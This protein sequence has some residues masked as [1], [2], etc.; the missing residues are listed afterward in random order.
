MEPTDETLVQR[1]LNGD[2]EAFDALVRRYQ[3]PI[4]NLAYRLTSDPEEANDLAQEIFLRVYERLH[5]FQPEAAFRPWLY[6]VATNWCLNALKR[7]RPPTVSLETG[8]GI[9]GEER[10]L[11]LPDLVED[12]ARLAERRELQERVQQAIL[13]L[14]PKYRIVMLLRYAQGLSYEEIATAL[15][16]PLGTVKIHL[17]RAKA[18]LKERLRDLYEAYFG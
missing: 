8:G 6:R 18:H 3:R 11:E 9:E 7:R 14:P 5:T 15:E 10:P 1:C 4:Y 17:H 16:M 12:P 13:T 2:T